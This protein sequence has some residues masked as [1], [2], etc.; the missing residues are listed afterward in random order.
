MRPVRV[1]GTTPEPRPS[2]GGAAGLGARKHARA[3]L[4]SAPGREKS[5]DLI[6]T[7]T[8]PLAQIIKGRRSGHRPCRRAGRPRVARIAAVVHR[9]LRRLPARGQPGH[10]RIRGRAELRLAAERNP[11]CP[12]RTERGRSSE[13]CRSPTP[14][15]LV[16]AYGE[17][18]S[19]EP[20]DACRRKCRECRD[21]D[22]F[23]ADPARRTVEWHLSEQ[24]HRHIEDRI[25]LNELPVDHHTITSAALHDRVGQVAGL[26]DREAQRRRD[27]EQAADWLSHLI[28]GS[29]S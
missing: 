21:L 18:W 4:R 5:D 19:I 8:I 2:A 13:P 9:V 25:W 20:A 12:R 29:S 24:Y 3:I 28:A 10:H 26:F 16:D 7:L 14:V 22:A 1:T 27:D 11:R 17:D 23:L 6:G 15:A